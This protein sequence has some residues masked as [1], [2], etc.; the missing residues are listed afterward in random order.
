MLMIDIITCHLEGTQKVYI[1]TTDY[2][3][4]LHVWDEV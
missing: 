1:P 2:C 3:V 4:N